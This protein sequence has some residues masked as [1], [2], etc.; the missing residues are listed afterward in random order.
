MLIKGLQKITKCQNPSKMFEIDRF[1]FLFCPFFILI[2]LFL[3]IFQ[4]K[5]SINVKNF[6]LFLYING[7]ISKIGQFQQFLIKSTIFLSAFEHNQ[8]FFS[9]HVSANGKLRQLGPK[10]GITTADDEIGP[11]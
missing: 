4:L 3:I 5:R 10:N 2:G 1:S 7:I 8:Y 9:R 6:D 11:N